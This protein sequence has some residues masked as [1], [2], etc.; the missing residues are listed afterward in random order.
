MRVQ[1]QQRRPTRGRG[2]PVLDQLVVASLSRI[3]EV[4]QGVSAD[5]VP[6]GVRL[7]ERSVEPGEPLLVRPLGGLGE[8]YLPEGAKHH[9]TPS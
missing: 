4:E 1:R 7:G 6:V 2:L 5:S 3:P 9:I 8:G